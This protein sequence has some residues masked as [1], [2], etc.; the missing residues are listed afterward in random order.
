MHGLSYMPPTVT[1]GQGSW[2]ITFQRLQAPTCSACGSA[3]DWI[4]K[5]ARSTGSNTAASA[6]AAATAAHQAALA[7]EGCMSRCTVQPAAACPRSSAH[8]CC[9]FAAPTTLS[10]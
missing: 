4:L 1:T 6:S 3:L 8:V 7:K 2:A 5:S 10:R 9:M